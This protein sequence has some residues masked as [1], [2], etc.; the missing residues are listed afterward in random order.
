MKKRAFTLMEIVVT[1]CIV[2]IIFFA[3]IPVLTNMMQVFAVKAVARDI[4]S[5]LRF[6]QEKAIALRTT[7][8]VEFFPKSLLGDP[9]TYYVERES[10][11]KNKT[12]VIRVAKL[13]RKFDFISARA[14]K[15]SSSGLPPAGGSGTVVIRD[16]GGRQKSVILSSAGRVRME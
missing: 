4:V 8:T 12:E 5:D 10:A 2:G 14:L 7:V 15:F 3:A 11:V 13:S 16:G 1:I 6:A 9:A